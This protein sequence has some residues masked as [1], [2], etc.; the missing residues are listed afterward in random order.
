LIR[1]EQRKYSIKNKT[2]WQ[3]MLSYLYVLVVP[4]AFGILIY[5]FSMNTIREE[6]EELQ[7]Q[8]VKRSVDTVSL[9]LNN[10]SNMG[11]ALVSDDTVQ[12]L[13]RVEDGSFN[14]VQRLN[15]QTINTT[16]MDYI[17][18]NDYILNA[19]LYFPR[20]QY[21]VGATNI[22]YAYDAQML[23]GS[24]W[25][26]KEEFER[27]LDEPVYRSIHL[28]EGLWGKICVYAYAIHPEQTAREQNAVMLVLLDYQKLMKD[29]CLQD[30]SV[31]LILENGNC[32][33]RKNLEAAGYWEV[34]EEL[35][36]EKE[37]QYVGVGEEHLILSRLP[38]QKLWL[39]NL[40]PKGLF[41][42]KLQQAKV[43]L[44]TY[45]IF[46][47]VLGVL[48]AGFLTKRNYSPV[49]ELIKLTQRGRYRSDEELG[50][51]QA[52]KDSVEKLIHVYENQEEEKLSREHQIKSNR[53][54]RI[55]EN[56]R[57]AMISDEE[58]GRL[59]SH[60]A[61][62]GYLLLDFNVSDI[63]DIFMDEE[64]ILSEET[65]RLI[66]F[67]INNVCAELLEAEG[68]KYAYLSGEYGRDYCFL[69]NVDT[70]VEADLIYQD[71]AEVAEKVGCFLKESYGL[72]LWINISLV[73]QGRKDISLCRD[74]ILDINLFR[75][76]A[77]TSKMVLLYR[78]MKRN[79]ELQNVDVY[80]KEKQARDLIRTHEYEAAIRLLGELSTGEEMIQDDSKEEEEQSE[81]RSVGCQMTEVA[82]Y[83][84][85]HFTD[86][87][88]SAGQL[89]DTFGMSPSNLSQTF[90]RKMNI[91]LL[92]YINQARLNRAKELLAT[93][94]TVKDTADEVGYYTTRPL[95]RVFYSVEGVSPAEYRS[96]FFNSSEGK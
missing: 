22:Y 14:T 63:S 8:T 6:A 72:N 18:S 42:E 21:L 35:E 68:S 3:W 25:M 57:Y 82:A 15:F 79:D 41:M 31:H 96:R 34:L 52:I 69:I 76:W 92:D 59:T 75:D 7:Y 62:E 91:G 44:T 89:A 47:S 39:L 49:D 77:G 11:A 86:K 45:V 55:L 12:D 19:Y 43:I 13:G 54:T 20:S 61:Y 28:V 73:H 58:F 1:M 80:F 23:R 37:Y 71:I 95:I 81:N 70:E 33:D 67:I 53:M 56:S 88:L 16:L 85:E 87:M 2:I 9:L 32:L 30:A 65:R 66:S 78:D 24:L 83:I 46:C 38:G 51:F 60:F 5:V 48:L 27:F 4:L 50:G 36:K 26:S 40:I 90:K 74:E 10:L 84:D 94:M 64:N 93:G 17:I 29:I